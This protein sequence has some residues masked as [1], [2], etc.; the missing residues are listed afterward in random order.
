MPEGLF[1]N[2]YL[3]LGHLGRGGF[4]STYLAVDTHL[5]S[6]PKCVVKQLTF[7][8]DDPELYELVRTRFQREAAILEALG[9]LCPQIP[10]LHA[11]SEEGG[12]LYLVQ[13]WIQGQSLQD[14]LDLKGAFAE[15]AVR[16]ILAGLLPVLAFI[17]SKNV[18][19]RDIK[20]SNIM[21][22][23]ADGLPYL[24]DFGAVKE[25][26]TAAEGLYGGGQ[27]TIFIGT[28][29]FAPPE[30]HGGKP[31]FASDLYSLGLTAVCLLTGR[32]PA[33]KETN[34][35][36][37]RHVLHRLR[38]GNW[39]KYAPAVG[40][41]LRTTLDKAIQTAASDRF[42]TAGE[43]M[44]TLRL[45]R[46]SAVAKTSILADDIL[47][48]LRTLAERYNT[49][50]ET[51]A[52]QDT[53]HRREL[54]TG[55]FSEMIEVC[56]GG[57]ELD[58]RLFLDDD[59]WGMR[60]AAYVY[61]YTHPN[62]DDLSALVGSLERAG[63]QP[64]VQHR[65]LEAVSKI[66]EKYGGELELPGGVGHLPGLLDRFAPHT[67]RHAELTRLLNDLDANSAQSAETEVDSD[68]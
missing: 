7:E 20:P 11:C 36:T 39:H 33:W 26:I 25:V 63:G 19:H 35:E 68:G 54:M 32:P 34:L 46:P 62:A 47:T 49:I 58:V 64:F 60:L 3:T 1:N 48:R 27:T 44:A 18:I 5:P 2:R 23:D 17:H 61:V 56:L 9:N 65:G 59:D 38:P 53:L 37:N 50:C 15:E 6:K 29:P 42:H 22:R 52:G 67:I 24:I 21:L 16:D 31:V 57:E 13:D 4:G 51:Y 30:Q 14:K 40:E 45:S 66:L 43:M 12:N 28:P 55:V 10:K 41:R 8:T